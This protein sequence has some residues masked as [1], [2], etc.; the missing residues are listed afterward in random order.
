M[1][2]G[3]KLVYFYRVR[4]DATTVDKRPIGY[5]LRFLPQ[6]HLRSTS[7]RFAYKCL[8]ARFYF[9]QILICLFCCTTISF[10]APRMWGTNTPTFTV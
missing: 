5:Q 9:L 1:W 10:G 8:Y 4:I 2:G 6:Y 7:A 3:W